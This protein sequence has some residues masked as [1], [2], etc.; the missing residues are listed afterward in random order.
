[1]YFYWIYKPLK[2]YKNNNYNS[3]N[4]I[5]NYCLSIILRYNRQSILINFMWVPTVHLDDLH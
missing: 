3:H 4:V 2:S 1:M 5:R